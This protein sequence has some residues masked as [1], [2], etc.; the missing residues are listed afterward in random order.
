MLR[1]RRQPDLTRDLE[2]VTVRLL[3]ELAEAVE[4]VKAAS[5]AAVDAADRLRAAADLRIE[6]NNHDRPE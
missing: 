5:R 1:R 6:E 2:Q 4:A 3:G